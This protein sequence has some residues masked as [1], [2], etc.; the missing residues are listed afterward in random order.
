MNAAVPPQTTVSVAVTLLF[1]VPAAAWAIAHDLAPAATADVAQHVAGYFFTAITTG[2]ITDALDEALPAWQ[3]AGGTVRVLDG[4]VTT[5]GPLPDMTSPPVNRATAAPSTPPEAPLPLLL[6]PIQRAAPDSA[7]SQGW[8]PPQW[9]DHE[10]V[11]PTWLCRV[12][13]QVWPC[14][15]RRAQLRAAV[16]SGGRAGVGL[17]LDHCLIQ[18]MHDQPDRC[19]GCLADQLMTGIRADPHRGS[20][21][22]P[23]RTGTT[24]SEPEGFGFTSE[25][26]PHR[27]DCPT[28]NGNDHHDD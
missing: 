17:L 22:P 18:L 21:H 20:G 7:T 26:P 27:P 12:C 24:A 3:P 4:V 13:G 11:R 5:G 25:R 19:P 6:L 1:E 10:P 16:N 2:R 8:W 14:Q 15:T 28:T 9:W 23:R